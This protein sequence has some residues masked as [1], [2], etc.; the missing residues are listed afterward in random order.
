M[1]IERAA[2]VG[3]PDERLGE[4]GCACVVLAPGCALD[5]ATMVERL[6]A[7]G[8]AKYK[9]PERLVALDALPLTATGKVQRHV[10]VAE[11]LNRS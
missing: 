7:A 6:Q 10:I 11:L 1:Q 2:V 4:R 3:L 8:L 9:L 5:M